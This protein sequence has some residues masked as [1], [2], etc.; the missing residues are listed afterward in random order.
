MYK[1]RSEMGSAPEH[2]SE[3]TTA[4]KNKKLPQ[5]LPRPHQAPNKAA[6]SPKKSISHS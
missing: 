1:S 6:S 2:L 4:L 5:H 3:S